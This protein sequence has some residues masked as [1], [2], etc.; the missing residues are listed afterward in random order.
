VENAT[1]IIFASDGGHDPESGIS[2]FGW[3]NTINHTIVAVAR[4]E[5]QA[6]TSMAEYFR[7]EGVGLASAAIF[8]NNLINEFNLSLDNYK[9]KFYLDN[10][11]MIT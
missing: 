9:W 4:G 3:V 2:T 1:Q 10:K 6:H 7:A 11:S 5:V 8:A